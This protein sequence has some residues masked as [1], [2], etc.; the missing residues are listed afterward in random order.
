[1]RRENEY[2]AYLIKEIKRRLPGCTILKND[3]NYMQGI[4]DLLILHCDRWAM[5]EVKASADA[6]LQPNQAY[7]VEKFG[8]MS[9]AAFIYPE[10]EKEV[11]D[12]LQQTLQS[13]GVRRTRV[14]QR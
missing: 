11:L 7:Y 4:L 1:M 6:K 13:C 9:F 12:A 8:E 3:A 5:L 2:Q 10:N 14:S